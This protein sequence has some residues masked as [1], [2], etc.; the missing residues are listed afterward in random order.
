VA[1]AAAAAE[2]GAAARAEEAREAAARVAG[3][4]QG[5]PEPKT[6]RGHGGAKAPSGSQ[7]LGEQGGAKVQGRGRA[8]HELLNTWAPRYPA[9]F[10]GDRAGQTADATEMAAAAAAAEAAAA[11]AAA[12]AAVPV[13][14]ASSKPRGPAVPTVT[15]SLASSLASPSAAT[16]ASPDRVRL[17]PSC[18]SVRGHRPTDTD[19]AV[20]HS[21]SGPMGRGLGGAWRRPPDQAPGLG[22]ERLLGNRPVRMIAHARVR[23]GR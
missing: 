20:T 19:T 18:E 22:G 3:R 10:A 15:V 5:E 16:A 7:V 6:L 23:A 2:P 17:G 8:L 1:A 4:G 14:P 11:A 12:A 9:F 21:G 13:V